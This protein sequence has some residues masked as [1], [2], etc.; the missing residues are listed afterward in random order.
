[1]SKRYYETYFILDGNLEE[2]SIEEIIK[3]YDS[4]LQKNDVEVKN[5]DRIGRRRLAYP[6]KRKQNG[7]YVCIEFESSPGLIT[8]L[9]RTYRL[10]ENILRF[11]TIHLDTKNLQDRDEHLTKKAKIQEKLEAERASDSKDEN[12]EEKKSDLSEAKIAEA[13]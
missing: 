4:F 10:D 1:L 11:L 9:E 6:I 7:F 8:K 13:T 2:T 3:K 12:T 5:I